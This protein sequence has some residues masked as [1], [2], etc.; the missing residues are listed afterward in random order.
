LVRSS[1]IECYTISSGHNCSGIIGVTFD[2]GAADK[3]FHFE[4]ATLQVEGTLQTN[5]KVGI[6]NTNPQNPLHVTGTDQ[7]IQIEGSDNAKLVFSKTG[8]SA[9]LG[10][11]ATTGNDFAL[12][13]NSSSG[14]FMFNNPAKLNANGEALS[15]V[16]A[17]HTFLGFY[18][19]GI[20]EGRSGYLGF[21]SAENNDIKL[22]NEVSGGE[23]R[24]T[25]NGG[26]IHVDGFMRFHG[27][28]SYYLSGWVY[29]PGGATYRLNHNVN[30]GLASDRA[31]QAPEFFAASD[32]RIKKDFALSNAPADL[33]RLNQIEVTDY[34]H[35]DTL[36]HGNQTVKGLIAQQVKSVYP[37]A[38]TFVKRS[39]PNIFTAPGS[40]TIEGAKATFSLSKT[41]GCQIGDQVE[42]VTKEA[43]NT[44]EVIAVDNDKSFTVEA[45][46]GTANPAEIFIY[47][48]EIENFH[49]VN[50]DRVFT[51]AVSATQELARKVE[52]LERENARLKAAANRTDKVLEQL[53][54]KVEDLEETVQM[55]G[56]R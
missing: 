49:I 16:G 34:R 18:P 17:E 48:K 22:E 55:T 5:G 31:M 24:L 10:F 38:V 36:Q 21:A 25:T 1:C 53:S 14:N 6:G 7:Q 30:V 13:N 27:L 20:S 11:D 9:T 41:H 28:R 29:N 42:I 54:A 12:T 32:R 35:I 26:D 23:I 47:G 46:K 37:E 44:Y 50:Y 19:K 52:F 3:T 39:I 33:A 43:N 15:L 45:W 51:L 2:A 40:V 4:E 56:N 8:N